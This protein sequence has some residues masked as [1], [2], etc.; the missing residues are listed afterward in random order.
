M[1][2]VDTLFRHLPAHFKYTWSPRAHPKAPLRSG[3]GQAISD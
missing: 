2:K 3:K 1:M